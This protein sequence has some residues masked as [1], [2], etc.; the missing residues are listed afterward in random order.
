M[1]G[2]DLRVCQLVFIMR[3]E[4]VASAQ[5]YVCDDDSYF[6]VQRTKGQWMSCTTDSTSWKS[7]TNADISQERAGTI[8]LTDLFKACSVSFTSWCLC[9][10]SKKQA[11]ERSN[12]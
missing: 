2:A 7:E 9:R 8:C 12:I 1:A 6:K 5:L 10:P 4:V 3:H 11:S